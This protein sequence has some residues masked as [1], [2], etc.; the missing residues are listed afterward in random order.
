[1]TEAP[2]LRSVADLQPAP[3]NPREIDAD[4][5]GALKSSLG[6]FGDLSGITWNARSGHLITGHQRMRALLEEHGDALQLRRGVL[7][8][9]GG[10]RFAV[11]IVD[12]D[13][14]TEK[15]ANIAANSAL[16]AGTFTTEVEELLAELEQDAPE[17]WDALRLDDLRASLGG[18][19][20]PETE[21]GEVPE[22]PKKPVTKPG[23]L[24]VLGDHRLLCGD[25]TDAEDVGQAIDGERADAVLTDPP[26]GI[27]QRGIVGD[28]PEGL[29][30]LVFGAVAN[31]PV[32]DAVVVAF[33]STRT[34]PVWLDAVREA[35]HVF[36]RMLWLYKAAQCTFPWRGW[37]LKS[38]AIVVSALGVGQWQ[39]VRPF[40]HDCYYLPEVSGELTEDEGWHGSVK[41]LSVV[42][43]ILSRVCPD[44]GTVYDPFLGSGSTL[45][46]AEQLGRR[47]FSLEIGP[48]YCDVIVERWQNLTGRKA[49]R[50]RRHG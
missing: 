5:L 36:H 46:A 34:F 33:Q 38:E 18:N 44:S 31:L 25:S 23:D 19:G 2:K 9:P 22:P 39:E 8:V 37:I 10:E 21:E 35:G 47:C 50:N 13:G 4:A 42:A 43:D 32:D 6:S 20:A 24:W 41:P 16:L 14:P 40:A 11:R 15:A 7:H 3:Y 17:M 30:A 45:V 26:Y 29:R 12:W 49:K 28:E 1:M 27:N 48:R